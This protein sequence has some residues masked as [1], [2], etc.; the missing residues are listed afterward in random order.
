MFLLL[1]VVAFIFLG[2]APQAHARELTQPE[3]ASIQD[4]AS[5]AWPDSRC[6]DNVHLIWSHDLDATIPDA[7]AQGFKVAGYAY[8]FDNGTCD[9][10]VRSDLP[11]TQ[12]CTVAVHEAGH[13]AG[14]DHNN[15]M[16]VMGDEDGFI[17]IGYTW[18]GCEALLWMSLD[19][20]WSY[21]A[22][23]FPMSSSRCKRRTATRFQCVRHR[24]G[25]ATRQVWVV[26]MTSPNT[27]RAARTK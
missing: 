18:P 1:L 8:G 27:F 16:A 14:F 6:H 3:R 17:D 10:G 24:D 23:R 19:D 11:P 13:L 7:A 20:A 15:G 9:A 25:R 12:A 2:L 4:A 21:M 22:E 5:R 26:W